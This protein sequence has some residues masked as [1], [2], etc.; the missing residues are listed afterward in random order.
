MF[1]QTLMLLGLIIVAAHSL[2]TADTILIDGEIERPLA[3]TSSD[4]DS[5]GRVELVVKGKDG[6]TIHYSGVPV[7]KVLNTANVP[8]GDSLRG[9]DNNKYLL[10]VGADGFVA[11][12]SLH[13]F[14]N[15]RIMIADTLNGH[16]IAPPDGPLLIV[17]PDEHRKARWVKQLTRLSI[18]RALL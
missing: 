4:F 10:A 17:S 12:F 8:T 11:L 7:S 3:I 9:R 14:D 6:N 13:E 15:G 1:S 16:P 2:G 5:L 18:R